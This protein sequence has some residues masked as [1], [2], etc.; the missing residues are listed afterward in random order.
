MRRVFVDT[1]VLV[2]VRDRSQPSKAKHAAA[3]LRALSR[4]E[5]A[6]PVLSAQVLRECY[7]AGLRKQVANIADLRADAAAY[8]T[9]IPEDLERDFLTEAWAWQDRA[10]LSFRDALLIAAACAAGCAIFLSEDLQPGRKFG[11]MEVIDPFSRAPQEI[12]G[13]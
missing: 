4:S 9:F 6:Q 11:Q 8:A 7:A 2:Y 1:N 13:A 12:L 3:W 5:Q 10:T